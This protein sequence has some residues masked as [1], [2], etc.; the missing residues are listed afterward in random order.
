MPRAT[1]VGP[2]ARPTRLSLAVMASG[3]LD[4]AIVALLVLA[5]RHQPARASAPTASDVAGR[6][7]TWLSEPGHG[8][9]GGGGGNRLN[10]PPR[11]AKSPG[12]DAITVLV[13]QPAAIEPSPPITNA[14]V[15]VDQ[16]TVPAKDQSSAPSLVPGA[17]EPATAPATVQDKDL[18]L[19]RE[20]MEDSAAM[21]FSRATTSRVPFCCGKSSRLTRQTRCER[22]CK[23][24]SF[25]GASSTGMA[26][27]A[28]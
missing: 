2:L 9:G 11:Q 15:P 22:T 20:G 7:L 28:T 10:E 6:N 19:D 17:I 26:A 4:V 5:S 16:L 12:H 23:A 27:S 21:C 24:R 18:A 1:S 25:S 3:A 13:H 14:P 8:G